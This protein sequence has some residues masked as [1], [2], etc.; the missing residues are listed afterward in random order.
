MFG[1][2]QN[3]KLAPVGHQSLQRL[4]F[5]R[6]QGADES[7]PLR[8]AGQHMG[9]S[10]ERRGVDPV[11]PSELHGLAEIPRL[12]RIDDGYRE[13][14]RLQQAGQITLQS[15]RSLHDDQI[16]RYARQ[17]PGDEGVVAILVIGEGLDAA[18]NAN[19]GFEGLFGDVDANASA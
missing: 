11:G 15:P 6:A 3:D 1:N 10:G 13:T 16:D 8:V 19:G 5:G 2:V 14:G 7:I 18:A 17:P 4:L 12:P 9:Q